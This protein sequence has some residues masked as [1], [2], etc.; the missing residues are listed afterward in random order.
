MAEITIDQ[1]LNGELLRKRTAVAPFNQDGVTF[2]GSI[3]LQPPDLIYA[4][5]QAQLELE[6]GSN[7][8]IL[9]GD[10]IGVVIGKS[11]TLTKPFK[12]GL[13][14]TLQ[15]FSPVPNTVLTYTGA[16]ALFQNLN[17]IN[18]IFNI[19]SSRITLAGNGTNSVFDILGTNIIEVDYTIFAAFD[20]LGT[21]DIPFYRFRDCAFAFLN[22][23][24]ITRNTLGGAIIN[25]A[26]NQST[27]TGL[28]LLTVITGNF[29]PNITINTLRTFGYSAGDSLLD[30]GKCSPDGSIF[31]V[32]DSDA[33]PG[34][35]FKV[36]P[37]Q[38][39]NSMIDFSP[40]IVEVTSTGPHNLIDGQCVELLG[41]ASSNYNGNFVIT[42]TGASA[43]FLIAAVFDG[44]QS[45]FFNASSRDQTDPQVLAENNEGVDDSMWT[46]ET[47]LEIFGAEVSS[48]SLAQD[49]FEVITSASWA[50][51]GLE[52]FIE[53]VSNEGQVICNAV[54]TRRYSIEYGATIEKSGGGSLDIG[55]VLLKNG[56]EIGFN[57][58]HTV[59]AG[60]V[61]I[62]RTNGIE[63]T[64][65]DTLQIAVKN[66][67]STAAT[68]LISQVSLKVSL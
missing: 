1:L 67:D 51:S 27:A 52:R 43:Q 16:G 41:F 4:L 28:T 54:K 7:I 45:G 10:N 33:Q 15:I 44:D 49:A 61:Q 59:N 2:K 14:S 58:P 3:P 20:S 11:F 35:L 36:L 53:G 40:G 63:L 18:A 30:F 31:T 60:K 66:Y 21:I 25:S 17:P 57:P 47:G 56:T 39:T 23:G 22:N 65:T 34:D 64:T 32:R 50:F 29:P 42:T 55:I 38:A 13:G 37:D 8:E 48:S 62:S 24:L 46:A 6:L 12:I 26:G 68:I 9:D 5:D 19:V